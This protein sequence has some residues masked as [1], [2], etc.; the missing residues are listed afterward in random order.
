MQ[1]TSALLALTKYWLCADQLRS[2]FFEAFR[3]SNPGHLFD[4]HGRVGLSFYWVSGPGIFSSL[5]FSSLFVVIEG[6]SEFAPAD[7]NIDKLLQSDHVDALRLYRNATFH[8]QSSAFHP[9]LFRLHETHESE[10]WIDEIHQ[11]LGAFLS[12]SALGVS[13]PPDQPDA[14]RLRTALAIRLAEHDELPI[15]Q[16]P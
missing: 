1:D 6:Y 7:P 14:A 12:R 13:C 16:L 3:A 10:Q 5:W 8:F 11:R 4:A 9:K 15:T 2:S